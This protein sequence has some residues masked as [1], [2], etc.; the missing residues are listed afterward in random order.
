MT[1]VIFNKY[2][3]DRIYLYIKTMKDKKHKIKLFQVGDICMEQFS[4][5]HGRQK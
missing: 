5:P 2:N 1:G 3:Q 4:S